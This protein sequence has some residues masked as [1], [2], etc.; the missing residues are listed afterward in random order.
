MKVWYVVYFGSSKKEFK[1]ESDAVQFY[2]SV[3][4]VKFD[5][6]IVMVIAFVNS[7]T[8]KDFYEEIVLDEF[9]EGEL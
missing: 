7:I 1:K 6:R 8:G 5:C 4:C 9:K 3:L 2:H